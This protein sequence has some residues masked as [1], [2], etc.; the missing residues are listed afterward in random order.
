MD[1]RGRWSRWGWTVLLL[2]GAAP[3]EGQPF[4]PAAVEVV[5]LSHGF[6]ADTVYWPSRPP[7]GFELREL[8][9]GRTP[10]GWFYAANAFSTPEHGGTHLDAPIHFAE[11]GR[12]VERIPASRLVARAVVIDASAAAA[13][14]PELALGAADVRAF[15]ARHG[16]IPAGSLVL[17]RTGWDRF[18]PDRRAYLGDDTPGDASKLRFPSFGESAARLLVEERGVAGLGVDTASIDVGS[19]RDFPVHRL[20]AAHDVYGL[21]NLTGLA[22]LPPVGAVVV[23]LPMKIEGGSGA[24][25]RAIALVEK[26]R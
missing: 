11:G 14:T 3:A 7:A 15:E 9:H 13:G 6:G 10:G 23:A 19:S 5:D 12:S 25:L 22:G 1:M 8:A 4:D 16:R 26:A 20:A 17:L 18:W 21:E 24:P 2:W